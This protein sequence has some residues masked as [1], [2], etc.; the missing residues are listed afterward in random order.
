MCVDAGERCLIEVVIDALRSVWWF[1]AG[2][3]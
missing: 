3:P 2:L 1:R